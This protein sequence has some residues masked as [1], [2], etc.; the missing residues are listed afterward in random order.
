MTCS[1]AS[2]SDATNNRLPSSWYDMQ[3]AGAFPGMTAAIAG[4]PAALEKSM[5]LNIESFVQCPSWK[6]IDELIFVAVLT[7]FPT[8]WSKINAEY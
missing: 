8:P 7:D 1:R 3:V 6:S 5:A 4:G 2:P